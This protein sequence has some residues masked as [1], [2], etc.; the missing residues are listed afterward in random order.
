MSHVCGSGSGVGGGL[1]TGG[2]DV[3]NI[4]TVSVVFTRMDA[5][6]F[7]MLLK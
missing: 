7:K 6:S 3:A 2:F 4:S 5:P 1:G